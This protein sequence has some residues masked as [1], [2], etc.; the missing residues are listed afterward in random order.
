MADLLTSHLDVD[1]VLALLEDG[2]PERPAVVR[3]VVR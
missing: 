2:A 3:G 1:A